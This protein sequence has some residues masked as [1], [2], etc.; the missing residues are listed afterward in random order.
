M[1]KEKEEKEAVYIE[2]L[3]KVI[4]GVV[5]RIK[6]GKKYSLKD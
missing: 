1:I 2:G 6:K 3:Y 5:H 4:N